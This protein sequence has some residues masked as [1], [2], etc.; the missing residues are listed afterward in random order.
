LMAFV[1]LAARCMMNEQQRKGGQ[2][3]IAHL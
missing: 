3:E 2:H 1:K